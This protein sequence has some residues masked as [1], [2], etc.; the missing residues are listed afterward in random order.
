M[1]PSDLLDFVRPCDYVSQNL[2]KMIVRRVQSEVCSVYCA[3]CSVFGVA[4]ALLVQ[5]CAV[6]SVQ[7]AVCEHWPAIDPCI[8]YNGMALFLPTQP[9]STLSTPLSALHAQSYLLTLH[10]TKPILC[11][12]PALNKC[13]SI[14]NHICTLYTPQSF[15]YNLV[16]FQP[17]LKIC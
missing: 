7:C 12:F 4:C 11:V 2:V 8:I 9:V 15:N 5:W 17:G 1:G 14:H 13:V 6:C 10:T 16:Y 3:E